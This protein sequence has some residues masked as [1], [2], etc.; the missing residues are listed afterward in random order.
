VFCGVLFPLSVLPAWGR[1]IGQ[2]IPLTY[3]FDITRRLLAP[4][5]NVDSTLVGYDDL[6]I[7]ALLVVSSI[8]FFALSV[9]IFKAGEYFARKAGKI[10]M[11]TSY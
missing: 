7:L 5:L 1:V 10:D 9:A 2:G 3:W 8:A 11:T 4:S 6:T